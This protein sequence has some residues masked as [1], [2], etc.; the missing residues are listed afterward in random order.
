MKARINK[1]IRKILSTVVFGTKIK[2]APQGRVYI[3][4]R[5][6]I[7]KGKFGQNI[8]IQDALSKVEIEKSY[9]LSVEED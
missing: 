1:M 7:T 6:G 8:V 4:K 9:C 2:L 5:L 3:V